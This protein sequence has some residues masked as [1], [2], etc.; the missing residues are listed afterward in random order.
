VRKMKRRFLRGDDD[1]DDEKKPTL[2]T[3]TLDLDV[4]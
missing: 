3:L 4:W 1:D 2:T